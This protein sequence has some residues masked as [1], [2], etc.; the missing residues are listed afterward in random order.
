MFSNSIWWL[1]T[2]LPS[3]LKT[4]N[5][6]EVVPQSMAPINHLSFISASV[7]WMPGGKCSSSCSTVGGDEAFS[8]CA[9]LGASVGCFNMS[10][11]L[12][13]GILIGIESIVG[14]V[15]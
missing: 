10:K 14:G 13:D 6:E 3:P 2:G 11:L 8:T 5:R 4:K 12:L 7:S 9:D 15:V 1:A